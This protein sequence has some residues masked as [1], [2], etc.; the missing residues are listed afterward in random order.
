GRWWYTHKLL[1][2]T[3]SLVKNA[4]PDMFHYLDNPNIQKSSNGLESQFSYLKNNL[5][6]HRGL[7]QKSRE[8]FVRWYYYFKNQK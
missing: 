3:R 8:N 1:R 5:K 2:R 4:L 7:S 6:I